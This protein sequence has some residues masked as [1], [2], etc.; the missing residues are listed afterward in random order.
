MILLN[1]LAACTGDTAK[2][3]TP[4]ADDTGTIDT[5]DTGDT[6]TDDTDETEDLGPLLLDVPRGTCEALLDP[7][8]PRTA[9]DVVGAWSI[10][11]DT[12]QF[13]TIL[14][15]SDEGDG[16]CPVVTTDG[17]NIEVVGGCT[18]STGWIFYGRGTQVAGDVGTTWTFEEYGFRSP[19]GEAYGLDGV[20]TMGGGTSE[21]DITWHQTREAETGAIDERYSTWLVSSAGGVVTGYGNIAAAPSGVHGDFCFVSELSDETSECGSV[22]SVSFT[23]AGTA[24]LAYGSPPCECQDVTID[25]GASEQVCE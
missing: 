15:S 21:I 17:T 22:G 16:S 12:R 24:T 25:D 5:D 20:A 3:T 10:A 14:S 2:D 23:G 4:A 9:Q 1:L 7:W 6:D 18:A 11:S 8:A 19:D 13:T